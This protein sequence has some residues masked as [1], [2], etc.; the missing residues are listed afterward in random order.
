MLPKPHRLT[1]SQDFT[2]VMRQGARAGSRTQVVVIQLRQSEDPGAWRCGFVVS[3]AVGN[4]VIRHRVA[5]RLRHL[6][7]DLIAETV[8]E[9]PQGSG[10]DVVVRALPASAEAEYEQLRADMASGLRRALRK[11]QQ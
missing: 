2:T 5:R 7:A 10:M 11:A 9:L 6:A 1:R 8:G 3:K 4:A